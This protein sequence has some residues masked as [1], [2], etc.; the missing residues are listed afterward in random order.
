MSLTSEKVIVAGKDGKLMASITKASRTGSGGGGKASS[1]YSIQIDINSELN[2][3]SLVPDIPSVEAI[4]FDTLKVK[5][6]TIIVSKRQRTGGGGGGGAGANRV[7][8]TMNGKV[9]AIGQEM[10][11]TANFTKPTGG[12]KKSTYLIRVQ[13]SQ[14]LSFG[15]LFDDLGMGDNPFGAAFDKLPSAKPYFQITNKATTK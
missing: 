14:A 11:L 13:G 8:M 9:D 5:Q 4:N 7:L 10:D 1:E 15:D 3:S 6:V 2:F 12:G